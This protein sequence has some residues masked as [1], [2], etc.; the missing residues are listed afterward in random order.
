MFAQEGL[1][2]LFSPTVALDYASPL[3]GESSRG[4]VRVPCGYFSGNLTTA[5]PYSKVGS[6]LGALG[7]APTWS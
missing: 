7:F 2:L 3:A 1:D 4:W 6:H 5:A